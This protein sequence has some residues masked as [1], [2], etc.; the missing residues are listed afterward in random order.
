MNYNITSSET[1]PTGYTLYFVDASLNDITLT[2]DPITSDYQFYNI[3][4]TDNSIYTVDFILNDNLT[5]GEST[6]NLYQKSNIVL[7]SLNSLWNII[8]GYS[9]DR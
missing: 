1:L 5:T 4:R 2:I 6:F 3:I 8:S 7:M 9:K